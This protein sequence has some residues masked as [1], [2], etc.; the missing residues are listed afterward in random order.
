MTHLSA[1][2][3]L[4]VGRFS[5][6]AQLQ[7]EQGVLVLFGPSGS[8]KSLTVSALAG[9]LRPERGRIEVGG[10]VVFDRAAGIHVPTRD[11]RVGYVPQHQSLFPFLDVAANVAFGLPRAE[12]RRDAPIVRE[13]LDELELRGLADAAPDSLS[14]GER[15]RV[16]F[17]RAL[18]VRPELLL[19]DEPFASIDR[20]GAERLRAVLAE[21]LRHRGTP[22]VMVTHDPRE[23]SA[24]GDRVVLYERGRTT[25]S[26]PPSEVLGAHQF[27][28]RG[29]LVGTGEDTAGLRDASVVGPTDR[30]EPDADGL[31]TLRVPVDPL[32]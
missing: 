6:Q 31:V 5:L 10:R 7:L 13:L 16:A 29:R 23:A 15:Q 8:G 2:F 21:V 12:R 4:T 11:R 28:V 18:A 1:D 19:L 20:A 14:G 9:L 17:A 24:L 22:T 26:G 32:P 30:L 3:A 25:R 27:L